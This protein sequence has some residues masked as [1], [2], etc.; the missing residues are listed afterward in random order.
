MLLLLSRRDEH[1]VHRC[2]H[3]LVLL[4]KIAPLGAQGGRLSGCLLT[5]FGVW[6]VVR[7]TW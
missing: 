7:G 3:N 2:A 5:A 1:L 4:E 6:M